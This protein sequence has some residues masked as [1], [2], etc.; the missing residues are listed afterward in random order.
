MLDPLTREQVTGD[1][2]E[3]RISTYLQAMA[4]GDAN[5]GLAT[6]V[7]ADHRLLPELLAR[8][9]AVTGALASARP[10]SYRIE[11]IEWWA[12]CCEPRPIEGP[13]N[14]G[15]ART[16]VKIAGQGDYVF[17]VLARDGAYWGDAAGYP[18]HNWTLRDVYRAGYP[19]L[20][21]AGWIR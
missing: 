17:D 20:F 2:P 3:A 6:W 10:G 11:R 12:T 16:Y 7:L 14:A 13:R 21:T 15:L 4:R 9:D 18:P 1:T 19:P 8:R 5:A